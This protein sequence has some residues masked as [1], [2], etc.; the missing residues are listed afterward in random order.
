M[1]NTDVRRPQSGAAPALAEVPIFT[2]ILVKLASRCNIDCTYCY[3]FRDADVY[4]KPSVLTVAAEDAFCQRLEEHIK[5]F[6]IETF[7]AVFHGGEPLLF[8]K[9]RFIALQD[10]LRAIEN[11][12]GCTIQRGVTTNAILIDPDWIK[13]FKTYDVMPSVSLDGPAEIH[14]LTR[15]VYDG[16]GTHAATLRGMEL[17]RAAGIEPGIISVCNPAT[18]PAKVLAY[19]VDDLGIK[20]F[21]ILPPDAKHGDDPP[22]IADYFIRLFDVWFDTYAAR[23][24]RINTID[25][26]IRGL[27]GR[28]SLCD[29]IGLGP[30]DTLTLMTDGT[31]EPHDVL[32]IAGDGS[33][34][35]QSSVFANQ[36]QDVQDDPRWLGAFKASLTL[37]EV[38]RACEFLDGC[39]GGHLA[40]RWSAERQFDNPSVY[41]DSWKRILNHI[42]ERISPTLVVDLESAAVG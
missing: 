32:R 19:I 20:E 12:T 41:C 37:P 18:D 38:C 5:H 1:T 16:K 3:W 11:R 17:L 29:T 24:V 4:K 13:I 14:D 2:F 40:Q 7:M 36:L 33:T 26:M 23:G 35:T 22:P 30:V 34:A 42:W 8:P 21:D 15:V 31:L 25:A 39:G 28:L 10:K 9:R 27:S 6:E